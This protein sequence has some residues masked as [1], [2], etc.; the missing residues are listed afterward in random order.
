MRDLVVLLDDTPGELRRLAHVL[1]TAG[2]NIE[3][4][5]ALT[6]QGRSVVHVLVAD[7]DRALLALAGADLEAR[8]SHDAVIANLP[9][10]PD[11]L[12]DA[13]ADVAAAG[14]NIRLTYLAV[15]AR[16]ATRVVLV[17]DDPDGT[18][19]VLGARDDLAG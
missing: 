11:A 1:G 16:S 14:I 3:G 7:H 4:L 15:G 12:A 6:G 8:A 17:T 2:I 18:R 9:D 5:A 10:R 19:A 13:L